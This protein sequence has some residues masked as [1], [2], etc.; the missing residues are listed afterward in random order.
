MKPMLS[1]PQIDKHPGLFLF[2]GLALLILGILAISVSVFTTLASVLF[3][4]IL[5]I[6]GSVVVIIDTFKTWRKD[7]KHFVLYLIFSILYLAAGIML[8]RHPVWGAVS[9]TLVLGIFYL[10]LGIFRIIG[11]I[12]LHLPHWGWSLL[13][14]VLALILGF[15]ILIHWPASSLIVIGLFIGIDLLFL[16]WTYVV[17]A[18]SAQ[19]TRKSLQT[20]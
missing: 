5:L 16:G 2:L 13:S 1:T 6:I 3:L 10:M 15:L 11:S 17:L 7:S 8:V 18:L 19:K 12:I 4:G 9:I 20:Q 14:G